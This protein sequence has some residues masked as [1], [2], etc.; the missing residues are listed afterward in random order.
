MEK[1]KSKQPIDEEDETI[2]VEA[3]EMCN[4]DESF[5]RTLVGKLWT[6]G[7]FN[8]RAF[9][10]T[11]I[12]AWRV[13][14]PIE[15]QDLNKN[16]FLF[17]FT[18]KRE[19]EQVWKSGP[20]SFDRN[21]LIL[22]RI[23][24]N[25]QPSE[26]AMDRASFW[27][28]VY[29]LPLKLRSEGIA[30]KL[31]NS[32]GMFEEM[33]LKEINRMG[34]FLRLRASINLTKPLKRGSKLHFQGKDIWVDYKYERLP[35]FC[36]ACGRIGHQMR[37]CEECEDPDAD[38]FRELE[39]KDQAYGPWLRASPLPKV[40]YEPSKESSSSACS[41]NLFPSHSNSKGQNSGTEVEREEEVEQQRT[42]I[43]ASTQKQLTVGKHTETTMKEVGD[44]H[45]VQ[46]E[47]EGV[48]E[49]LGEVSI[50][51]LSKKVAAEKKG[52]E[53]NGKKW[54]RQKSTKPQNRKAAKT[55]VKELGKRSLVEVVVTEGQFED[56]WGVD[57]R[58]RR[59]VTME[60]P[61]ESTGTVVLD[62]QHRQEP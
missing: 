49:S 52:K 56:G 31:G 46:D 50:S 36:F 60:E 59:D 32:M 19:A 25:E 42:L 24:G 16:L 26:L 48:A 47:V 39:E 43:E 14:N 41:K 44:E 37:D 62:D 51:S 10:Q 58:N 57:K 7:P 61:H 9:K 21:L 55:V 1:R 15:I 22:N 27:V 34:K 28:R 35:N 8:I 6:E 30:K 38:G 29:D 2:T 17:K 20:W 53:R 5:S 18:S 45:K 13:R 4:D 23:S 54:V 12:Q 33:D 11:M 3:D 40:T